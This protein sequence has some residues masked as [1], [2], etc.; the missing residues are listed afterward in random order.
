[1]NTLLLIVDLYLDM[2]PSQ[3]QWTQDGYGKPK[4]SAANVTDLKVTSYKS[5]YNHWHNT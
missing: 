5:H 4:L 1:M 3:Q 2:R